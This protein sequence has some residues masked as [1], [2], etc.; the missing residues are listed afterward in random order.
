[1][2]YELEQA[3]LAKLMQECLDEEIEELS[4]EYDDQEELGEEDHLETR[5]LD[6]E[7]EQEI[8][9]DEGRKHESQLPVFIGKDGQTKWEKHIRNTN[10]KTR[11]HNLIKH[12]PGPKTSTKDLKKELDIWRYFLSEDILNSIVHWTNIHIQSFRTNYQR[13]RDAKDTDMLEIQ[14]FFG[15]LYLAGIL[16]SNRSTHRNVTVEGIL[17][18][19]RSTH[20]NV[21]VDNWFCNMEILNC[22]YTDFHLTLLVVINGLHKLEDK[23]FC[24]G[25]PEYAT[26]ISTSANSRECTGISFVENSN[27]TAFEESPDEAVD[28]AQPSTSQDFQSLTATASVHFVLIRSCISPG[29]DSVI[30]SFEKRH[31]NALRKVQVKAVR[32]KVPTRSETTA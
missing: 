9:D 27:M 26:Y 30:I 6:S 25:Q 12:V 18:S 22:L 31:Q 32:S 7:L 28:V 24:G 23:K 14:A 4:L 1:M 19:N 13:E 21:T 20:R 8:S 16:K 11:T 10:V 29:A 17:K 15:L 3:R 5:D 2:S